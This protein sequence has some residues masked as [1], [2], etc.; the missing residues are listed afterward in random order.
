MNEG[1]LAEHSRATKPRGDLRH[2]VELVFGKVPL[3][4]GLVGHDPMTQHIVDN[5]AV[6]IGQSRRSFGH[7]AY[8]QI[9]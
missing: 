8:H 1:I 3:V 7:H 6:T 4:Q 2:R 5:A 9:W